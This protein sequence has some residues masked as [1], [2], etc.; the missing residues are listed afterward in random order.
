MAQYDGSIRLDTKVDNSGVEKGLQSLKRTALKTA[1]GIGAGIGAAVYQGIKFESAFAGVKKTVN[2]TVEELDTLRRGILDMSSEMPMAAN[3]IAQIAESAGQLGIKTENIL[4]FTRTIA[5]L[6]VATNLTGEQAATVLARF[7]NITQMPQDNFDRLGATIVALGNNLATTEAEIAEM[8]LRLAGA[9]TQAGIS[10]AQI[11]GIAGAL[12]SVGLQ[13]DAG[14]SAF[15]RV[16]SN[17]QIAVETANKDLQNFA[18][19]AGMS[20]DEFAQAF[21]KD[22]AGAL[23]EFIRGL[24]KAEERGSSAIKMLDD[25]GISEIIMRD[26]LLRASGAADVFTD[27][28]ALSE[29]A[30]EENTALTKEAEQRYETLES[31][32]G[33]L[34]NTAIKTG[35]AFYDGISGPIRDAVDES[36][37][38]VNELGEQLENGSLKPA[39]EGV[40]ELLAGLVDVVVGITN[41]ALPPLIA[42]LGTL[43]TNIETISAVLLPAGIAWATYSAAVGISTTVV[44]AATAAQKAWN[45]A[46][47]AHPFAI[48]VAAITAIIASIKAFLGILNKRQEASKKHIK[49]TESETEAIK[50]ET[51]AFDD[52]KKTADESISSSM[53]QIDRTE[54]LADEL[55]SLADENGRVLESDKKRANYILTELNT[56]LGTE[57]S[58]TDN[59][60]RKYGELCDSIDLLLLKKRASAIVEAN[61]A[62]YQ[63]A[64]SK[65]ISTYQELG[66]EQVKLSD[67]Q[68]RLK[69]GNLEMGETTED[70]TAKISA[71]KDK[72]EAIDDKLDGYNKEIKTSNDLTSAIASDSVPELEKAL[73][74]YSVQLATTTTETENGFTDQY[75]AIENNLKGSI[76]AWDNAKKHFEDGVI[77]Q[78]VLKTTENSV[79]EFT[80]QFRDMGG[81]IIYTVV[82]DADGKQY[83]LIDKLS[84]I[85]GKSKDAL[86]SEFDVNSVTGT[87]ND[88]SVWMKNAAESIDKEPW[89]E[90]GKEVGSEFS[91]GYKFGL[92]S[93]Q[94]EVNSSSAEMATS[95]LGAVATAQDSNSPSRETHKLGVDFS[96]GYVAGINSGIPAVK[97]AAAN[98]ALAAVIAGK[99]AEESGSPS[100][101]TAREIGKPFSQG[102]AIGISDNA[103]LAEDAA[104]GAV[105]GAVDAA[106]EAG[107]IRSPSRLMRDEVGKPLVDGIA[108]GIIDN[109]YK[110]SD[111]IQN[112]FDNLDL[113]LDVGAIDEAEYYRR[114]EF[115]RDEH[116]KAGTKQWWDYT[117]KLID[118]EKKAAEEAEEADEEAAKAALEAFTSSVEERESLDDREYELK[119]RLGKLSA[120]DEAAILKS[121]AARY[122]ESAAEIMQLEQISY[123]ERKK[124]A[125]EYLDESTDAAIEAYTILQDSV[126]QQYSALAD[127]L[128]EQLTELEQTRDDLMSQQDT[129]AQKMRDYLPTTVGIYDGDELLGYA[130]PDLS[131]S[132][133][134][135]REYNAMLEQVRQRTGGA[136]IFALIRDMS[137]EEGTRW[138]Q[139][140]LGYSDEDL[141]AYLEEYKKTQAYIADAAGTLYQDEFTALDSEL[142]TLKTE[143]DNVNN[144]WEDAVKQMDDD[145][146]A[147]FGD[148]PDGFYDCGF[149]S[150]DSFASGFQAALDEKM[151]EIRQSFAGFELSITPGYASTGS[152][153]VV[154]NNGDTVYNLGSSGETTTE[155]L[156]AIR[157]DETIRR[158]GGV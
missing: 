140:L 5:D 105:V 96:T 153:S 128:H 34:K 93:N 134:G 90:G 106:K 40:G 52:R 144:E 87:G 143:L 56:A 12:S 101:K 86:L 2:A 111:A 104:A 45:L 57:Y 121:K 77:T 36:V 18:A 130:L 124:L 48:A 129:F 41:V 38:N 50:A 32:L 151:A 35:I 21:K 73:Q 92:T 8:A 88:M 94:D 98:L 27:A 82:T 148:V 22:A 67:L 138:G 103:K 145:L 150:A 132:I 125:R 59:V 78:E 55:K 81:N 19:V 117:K 147:W 31:K 95:A 28:L 30:W 79:T 1:A 53:A 91:L 84:E 70:L 74:D 110:V 107:I 68:Q 158:L 13:A 65:Q 115:L 152:Q 10:E 20:A 76:I 54:A 62:S 154:Y 15:S 85:S 149:L 102:V 33:I 122:R 51:K 136:D 127:E 142:N 112:L 99:K 146:K 157:R 135:L 118:Y 23:T 66:T 120:N 4:K 126:S 37:G 133:D 3:G 97:I 141:N 24:S 49:I 43:G 26:A 71:Q 60:I 61:S 39:V 42:A 114:L 156:E 11:M 100:K 72:I 58:M 75:S 63:E 46:V 25:M 17:M 108:V 109:E 80:K 9:G 44:K 89:Y 6:G 119:K 7:A 69:D 116:I 14:G 137:I 155:R 113:E 139:T 16:I 47:K 29:D 83:M 131:K 64:L 123:D